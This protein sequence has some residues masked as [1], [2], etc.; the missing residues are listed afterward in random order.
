MSSDSDPQHLRPQWIFREWCSSFHR[1]LIQYHSSSISTNQTE[2]ISAVTQSTNNFRLIITKVKSI[3]WNEPLKGKV[4]FGYQVKQLTGSIHSTCLMLDK[5]WLI[6]SDTLPRKWFTFC[7]KIENIGPRFIIVLRHER[8]VRMSPI[9]SLETR[10]SKIYMCLLPTNKSRFNCL[11]YWIIRVSLTWISKI[12]V[13]TLQQVNGRYILFME[14]SIFRTFL[15][16][17]EYE[18]HVLK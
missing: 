8:T 6:L 12:K 13:L 5:Y 9:G 3:G 15:C 10:T 18:S 11:K 7:L 1:V 2:P 4:I 14:N 17:L 16:S